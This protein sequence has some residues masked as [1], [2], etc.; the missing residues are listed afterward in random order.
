MFTNAFDLVED[1]VQQR[2]SSGAVALI[3]F[4]GTIYGPSAF[5]ALS[6]FP[7][8][9]PMRADAVFDLASLSKVVST[10]TIAL[11]LM[12]ENRLHLE[13]TIERFY[14]EAPLDKKPITIQHLLTHTSGLP[15][16]APLY[17]RPEFRN[18]KTALPTILSVPL[19]RKPGEAVE[20][21]CVGFITLGLIME[22]ITGVELDIL[23]QEYV[24]HPLE[25]LDTDTTHLQV[26]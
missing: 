8:A 5:G 15:A 20:Y 23:F 18:K 22:H 19:V 24:S 21:S 26:R 13:D 6:F 12:E 2:N 4:Q 1:F 16:V 10:T 25:M 17:Q 9:Q 11:K 7:K 3:G 14:P